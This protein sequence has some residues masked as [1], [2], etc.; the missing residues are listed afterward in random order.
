MSIRVAR[1]GGEA[2]TKA[3]MYRAPHRRREADRQRGRE[4]RR[5]REGNGKTGGESGV[6]GGGDGM[7]GVVCI[8][9]G[10]RKEDWKGSEGVHGWAGRVGDV[11]EGSR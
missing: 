7:S 1:K 9:G 11:E 5:G 8:L 4:E 10:G 3:F 6:Y 2:G